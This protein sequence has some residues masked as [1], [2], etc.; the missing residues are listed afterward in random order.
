[1]SV[2]DRVLPDERAE[3]LLAPVADAIRAGLDALPPVPPLRVELGPVDGWASLEGGRLTLSHRLEGPGLV[4]PDEAMGPVP[5][6]DRWRRAAACVLEAVALLGL[7]RQTGRPP[8]RDWRWTGAAIDLADRAAPDLGLALPDLAL[9]IRTGA[10]GRYPRAGVAVLRAW[11]AFGEEPSRRLRHLLTDGVI[12]E[13]EWLAVARWVFSPEGAGASLPVPVARPRPVGLPVEL[14]PWSFRPL[15][16]DAHPRGG[17]LDVEGPGAVADAW[18]PGG[19]PHRTLAGATS[20]PCRITGASGGPVGDWEVASAQGFGQV[21][22]ARGVTFRFFA[23]GQLEIVL[24]DAF[25]GPLAALPMAE[26]VGTSG[27]VR[28]RWRVAGPHRLAF[29]GVDG[30]GLTLHG[31]SRDRF[32]VPARGFGLAEWLKALSG[33]EWAWERAA[34]RLVMR[35]PMLG[36]TVEVRLRE[37]AS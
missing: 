18:V 29:E 2:D 31:R 20:G 6:L 28:G 8:E 12:S 17:R 36:G 35:G 32:M 13:S 4:H 22:G 10:P 1:M 5:P 23:S 30:Q 7:T 34:D 37:A 21:V 14:E 16:L 3:V 33:E 24:A 26:Q 19:V 27:L 11:R 15:A 25:V 9:A